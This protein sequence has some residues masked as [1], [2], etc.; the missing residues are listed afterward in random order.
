MADY[1]KILGVEKGAS[2]EEIKKAYRK[3]AHKYH[4]DKEGGDE[5]KFKEINEAY[6]V[7]SDKTKRGQYDQFGQTFEGA[8]GSGGF[9]GF[10]GFGQGGFGGFSGASGWEDVFSDIFG[11][12][13]AGFHQEAGRDIQADIEITFK[14]MVEGVKRNI[15]LYKN[16]KCE[17][18]DGS[19]GAPGAKEETCK[20]CNGSGKIRKSIRTI[21]GTI[22]QESVCD[23]CKGRGRVYTEKCKRCQ[24]EGIHKE[25]KNIVVDIPAGISSGQT[26]S[27]RGEGE[28]GKHG[29][30]NGD[31]FINV[32]IRKHDK[33]ARDEE[34][35]IIS[36]EEISFAQAALGD[37]IEIET[38]EGKVSMKI[39]AGTQNGEVFRI[40]NMGVPFLRGGGRGHHLV[41]IRVVVPKKLSR[42]E[43]ELIGELR[44]LEK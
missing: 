33:F 11:N 9:S 43:K 14:E 32:H 35:N 20:D 36:E 31:L 13:S 16:V 30:P 41:K 6:Q 40:R 27:V 3:L 19:G 2:E 12:R 23:R 7:L 25:E 18:C 39:P 15:K 42:R 5:E 34:N 29:A 1:Y 22:A 44:D 17:V 4:P 38:I 24:G 37:K 28:A 8:G 21:L 26:I 10:G